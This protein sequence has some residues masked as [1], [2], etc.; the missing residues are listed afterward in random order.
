MEIDSENNESSSQL[1]SVRPDSPFVEPAAEPEP[2]NAKIIDGEKYER[3]DLH[4]CDYTMTEDNKSMDP[5]NN[6]KIDTLHSG[7]IDWST[8]KCEYNNLSKMSVEET[9]AICDSY[10][11]EITAQLQLLKKKNCTNFEDI[12]ILFQVFHDSLKGYETYQRSCID[13]ACEEDLNDGNDDEPSDSTDGGNTLVDVAI[14]VAKLA[15]KAEAAKKK[16]QDLLSKHQSSDYIFENYEKRVKQDVE[17]GTRQN[18]NIAFTIM[19]M[20]AYVIKRILKS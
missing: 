11:D 9:D 18:K 8:I 15:E 3:V 17:D 2:D 13:Q 12:S 14:G 16:K 7:E 5:N 4:D 20:F 19:S 10:I 1:F 6:S